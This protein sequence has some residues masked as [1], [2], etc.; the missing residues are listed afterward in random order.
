[1]KK[2]VFGVC[3]LFICFMM[4]SCAGSPISKLKSITEDIEKNGNDWTDVEKWDEVLTE[5]ANCVIAFAE[6]DPSKEE[7]E[8]FVDVND[9]LD[10]ATRDIDD[11]KAE[12]ALHKAQDKFEKN[13]KDLYKDLEKALKKIRKMT[14]KY[15]KDDDD[16]DSGDED[17]EYNDDDE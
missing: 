12:K 3:A 6:S 1:M 10:S 11:E 9:D 17:D 15:E 2:L 13:H 8:E 5:A 4:A 16:D 14:K 7:I